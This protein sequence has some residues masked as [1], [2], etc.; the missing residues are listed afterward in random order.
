M[1]QDAPPSLKP[2]FGLSASPFGAEAAAR[3]RAE[4]IKRARRWLMAVAIMT[5]VAGVLFSMMLPAHMESQARAIMITN[6]V[7]GAFYLGM[8]AWAKTNLLGATAT[9]LTVFVAVIVINAAI[10]PLSLTQGLLV[11]ILFTAA[12]VSSVREALA[13]R[14]DRASRA[15]Q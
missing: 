2:S 1:P 14:A 11:K 3:M 4:H 5:A 6:L 13:D 10:D 8:W 15:A 9:A 7:L 12:L